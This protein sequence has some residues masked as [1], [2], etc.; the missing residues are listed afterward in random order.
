MSAPDAADGLGALLRELVR[1]P[2]V[3]PEGG[4]D[5]GISGEARCAAFLRDHLQNLGATASLEEVRP[6]R[7]NVIGRF[8]SDRP[9]KPVLVLAPHT[10]T[11]NVAGMTVDPFGGDIVDGRLTGRGASDTKGSMAAMLWALR[12][13]GTERL[14]ALR[15]EIWFVGLMG[16]ETGQHGAKDFVGRHRVD[17]A[18][19]G[20]PTGLRTVHT[21]KGSCGLF[22]SAR[23][24]AAHSSRPELGINAIEPV[25]DVLAWLRREVAPTLAVLADPVLGVPTMSIAQVSGGAR[26]NIVPENCGAAVDFRTVPAQA[27]SGFTENLIRNIRSQFP[28]VEVRLSESLPLF[29]DPAHPLVRLLAETGDGLAGAPW[30]CD[31]AVFAAAGVPAVAAGPG[32]VAQAHTKDEFIGLADLRAGADFFRD[33]LLRLA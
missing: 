9:G 12:G 20:E 29:T 26:L 23:G 15:H 21:H 3:N 28:D 19:A 22:L 27:A 10:D 17:F 13:V 25:L 18:I 4:E 24:R 7:P 33:F 5:P 1:I 32:S 30:F 14:A 11:V 31:A 6:G 16:E 8:P 2:S